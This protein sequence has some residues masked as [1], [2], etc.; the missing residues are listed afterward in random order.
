MKFFN[1][2]AALPDWATAVII[3]GAIALIG[4]L[5][6]IFFKTRDKAPDKTSGITAKSEPAEQPVTEP[7]S[8][9]EEELAVEK[10]PEK[11]EEKEEKNEADEADEDEEAPVKQIVRE[12]EH[13]RYI[14]IKYKKSFTAK[15]IQSDDSVKNYYS[16]LK[17]ELLSYNGVKARMSWKYETFYQGRVTLAK[18][19]MRGKCPCLFLALDTKNITD[20]KYIVEDM[21][22]VAAYEKTPCLYRI[23][24]D[25]RL[26]YSRELIAAAMGER[27]K[28]ENYKAENFAEKYPY[29]KI[30]P[31]IGRGLVKVLTEEDA[32]SGD[33]FKPRDYVQASEVDELMQDEVAEALIEESEDISDRTKSGIINIDTLSK[34]FEDGE[35]VTLE[36][37]KKRIS[38]VP[39]KTTYIKVLAR[40]ALDKKL[41]VVAD[42]FSI[43]AAKMILL[44]GGY[45][46]KKKNG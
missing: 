40:G 14:I 33:V 2:S 39:K 43:E 17:N 41:T 34:Y 22:E 30:E 18:I 23:K 29:E 27:V 5:L 25:R 21:S 24:N 20:D 44:T 4:I 26:K 15:L 6:L 38:D 9:V 12:G 8:V 13:V 46:I 36:E 28:N 37:I 3:L 10:T 1:L 42:N 35:T 19:A 45:V 31:L 11:A 16:E 32:Q 7:E